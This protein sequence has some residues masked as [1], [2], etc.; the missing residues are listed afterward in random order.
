MGL[1]SALR[2]IYP[3]RCISCDALLE[4]DF[5]LCGDCWR[6]TPFIAGLICDTCGLP[7]P[8]SSDSKT[9]LCDDCLVI[10]RPWDKGRAALL[11][12]RN[13]RRLVLALKHGD[14]QELAIPAARWM[15]IPMQDLAGPQTL[16]VPVP[17]H[18][19]RLIRRRYNQAA[20]LAIELS[21]ITGN[22]CLPDGLIRRKPTQIQ[23]GMSREERFANLSG[24]I[25]PHRRR[26]SSLAGRQVLLVDDVMTSGATF[27]AATEA[28]FSAGVTR[29]CVLALARVA[30]DA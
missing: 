20:L 15:A 30:K 5:S 26:R 12:A 3:A 24:A 8:G 23:D 28:C 29:V 27:A 1:Q 16:I 19:S 13:A 14:R 2:L 10:A 4:E 7:L 18:W 9:E 21:R 11:Y 17:A 22:P 25:L 6:E